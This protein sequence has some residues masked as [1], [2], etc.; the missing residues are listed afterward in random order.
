MYA[1]VHVKFILRV[2]LSFCFTKGVYRFCAVYKLSLDDEVQ[3]HIPV[4][5]VYL[6]ELMWA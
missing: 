1:H 6:F 3:V 4:L 2:T 5:H